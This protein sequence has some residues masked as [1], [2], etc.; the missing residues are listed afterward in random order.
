MKIQPAAH[1]TSTTVTELFIDVQEVEKD[2]FGTLSPENRQ[3][4][5]ISMEA[6]NSTKDTQSQDLGNKNESTLE[7]IQFDSNQDT[8][9]YLE[10][11][12]ASNVLKSIEPE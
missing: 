2:M 3:H 9:G 11:A 10:P 12:E 8:I 1:V 5:E 7:N 6:S 4:S